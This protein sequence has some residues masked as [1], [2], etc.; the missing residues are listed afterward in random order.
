MNL[1]DFLF[2]PTKT[3]STDPRILALLPLARIADA[4][5]RNQLSGSAQKRGCCGENPMT[6]DEIVLVETR[7]GVLLTLADCMKARDIIKEER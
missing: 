3:K 2:P 7:W 6:P 4:Y 5:D 1:I